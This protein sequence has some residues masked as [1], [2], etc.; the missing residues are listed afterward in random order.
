MHQGVR[1]RR[2]DRPGGV[3]PQ[4]HG[5]LGGVA[6]IAQGDRFLKIVPNAAARALYARAG[7]AEVGRRRGYY[8]R[9]DGRREDALVLLPQGHLMMRSVAMAFDAYLSEQGAERFSRTV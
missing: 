3:A 9:P 8:Q 5:P 1:A 4:A 6:V 2:A 7:F